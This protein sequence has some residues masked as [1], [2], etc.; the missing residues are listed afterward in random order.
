MKWNR[1]STIAIVFFFFFGFFFLGT[2]ILPPACLAQTAPQVQSSPP[3]QH[4]TPADQRPTPSAPSAGVRH[5]RHVRHNRVQAS[6]QPAAAP[7]SKSDKPAEKPFVPESDKKGEPD[8]FVS[9][10]GKWTLVLAL[11]AL[12]VVAG[13]GWMLY[14]QLQLVAKMLEEMG[15]SAK[16]THDLAAAAKAQSDSTRALAENALDQAKTSTL[17]AEEF[18]RSADASKA[19]AESY[20]SM[21]N[22]TAENLRF[23]QQNVHLEQRAWVSTLMSLRQFRA[24][25]PILA[26]IVTSNSGKT[27]ALHVDVTTEVLLAV[28]SSEPPRNGS[29]ARQSQDE[30]ARNLA[31]QAAM[32]ITVGEK[33]EI[34]AED[35]KKIDD[36]L[37]QYTLSGV[38]RYADI[39]GNCHETHFCGF[40]DPASKA[41][42][43]YKSGNEMT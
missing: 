42:F 41:I 16:D 12:F 2:M 37:L 29:T 27:P 17:L 30:Q 33:M 25:E 35:F 18:K 23:T 8:N 15:K 4:A 11:L 13:I 6:T 21:A 26:D 24:G 1:C 3:D 31:P 38:I 36:G 7:T 43:N 39:F 22:S 14:L 34:A 9:A 5:R 20:A 32:R 40:I 28:P 19:S 10:Y